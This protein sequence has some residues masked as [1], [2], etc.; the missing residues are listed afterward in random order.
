M[1][2][3]DQPETGVTGLCVVCQSPLDQEPTAMCPDCGARMHQE[4][5]DYNGGCG[6]YGCSRSPPTESLRSLEIPPSF[7]GRED[8]PC[9][10]CGATILAA[11]V[12]CRHCGAT[13]AEATPQGA[14]AYRQQ[15]GLKAALPGIRKTSLVW[16]VLAFIPCT[17]PVA[18][19][20]GS[21]W[22]L[23]N[24]PAIGR[25][26]PLHAALCKIAIGVAWLQTAL[27]A[28]IVLVKWLTGS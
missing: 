11:A 24:R 6:V 1:S 14:M 13:F 10:N 4:C 25:L 28:A 16:L 5:W 8:K 2:T 18:A 12:R 27:L 7:W 15:Q 17:S 22:Y 3:A 21:I 23:A 9:P 26:P 19:V 20:G